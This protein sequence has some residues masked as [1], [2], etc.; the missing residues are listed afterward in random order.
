MGEHVVYVVVGSGPQYDTLAAYD[1][2]ELAERH[3]A[4]L[5]EDADYPDATIRELPIDSRKA[6]P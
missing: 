3:L 5:A 4:R 6:Q 2:R 1:D